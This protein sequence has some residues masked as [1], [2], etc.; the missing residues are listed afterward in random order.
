MSVGDWSP[1]PHSYTTNTLFAGQYLLLLNFFKLK[2]TYW[3][4]HSTIFFA[5]DVFI[6]DAYF[7]LNIEF[8]MG[9]N[10]FLA[11]WFSWFLL[12]LQKQFLLLLSLKYSFLSCSFIIIILSAVFRCLFWCTWEWFVKFI[13]LFICYSGICACTMCVQESMPWQMLRGQRVTLWSQFFLSPFRQVPR[14]GLR[15]PG[16]PYKCL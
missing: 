2:K 8:L 13:Y 14:T 7:L 9:S 10:F 6:F 5:C 3:Q 15:L 11:F 16:L 1:G 4:E 12:K